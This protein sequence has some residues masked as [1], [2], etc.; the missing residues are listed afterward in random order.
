MFGHVSV[1][2]SLTNGLGHVG[3]HRELRYV[4]RPRI[5][6]H[7]YMI[8]SWGIHLALLY[9]FRLVSFVARCS[10][11]VACCFVACCCMYWSDILLGAFICCTTT[12]VGPGVYCPARF[13]KAD[14]S[15]TIIDDDFISLVT[16][17]ESI[18]IYGVFNIQ[19]AEYLFQMTWSLASS[20][21]L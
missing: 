21:Y 12:H 1:T 10:L 19:H 4:G 7:I 9:Y 16:F 13:L 2:L 11:L 14:G 8:V 6:L 3:L 5:C 18:P 20:S 15:L 17:S